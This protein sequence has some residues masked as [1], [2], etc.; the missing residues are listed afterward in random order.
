MHAEL[1]F[2]LPRRLLLGLREVNLSQPIFK[3]PSICFCGGG[4]W[5]PDQQKEE[6]KTGA[7]ITPIMND[8]NMCF[9]EVFLI[10]YVI[11]FAYYNVSHLNHSLCFQY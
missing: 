6:A 11:S 10:S 4:D 1:R 8:E 5:F 2:W 3:Y 7:M 9:R